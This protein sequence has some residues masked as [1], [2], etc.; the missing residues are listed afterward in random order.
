[1]HSASYVLLHALRDKMLQGTE[2]AMA[3]MKT[4]RLRLIKVAAYVREMKTRI[5]IE[6]PKQFPDMEVIANCFRKF[7]E[8]R[9]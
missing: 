1:M 4:I 2:Y 8:L 9:C 5:K 6:L 3:T 7:N